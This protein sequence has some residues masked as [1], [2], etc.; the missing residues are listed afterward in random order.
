M[1][2]A[3]KQQ[4]Q[5]LMFSRLF[6]LTVNNILLEYL[7]LKPDNYVYDKHLILF[8]RQVLRCHI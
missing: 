1:R 3:S 4:L 5:N 7:K 2:N 8:S 6:Y